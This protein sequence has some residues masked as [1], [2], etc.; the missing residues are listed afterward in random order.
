[1][2]SKACPFVLFILQLNITDA[3]FCKEFG[4]ISHQ[5]HPLRH[6]QR[7]NKTV[8]AFSNE[9]SPELCADFAKL[10]RGLAFNFSPIKRSTDNQF[11]NVSPDEK[12]ASDEFFN[13]EVLECPEFMNFSS[14]VNDTRF[15]YYSLYAR[16]PREWKEA[17]E[18]KNWMKN[19]TDF[20]SSPSER[21]L[22]MS[23][24]NRHVYSAQRKRQLLNG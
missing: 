21:N 1:M 6:C 17:T 16:P 15:D 22:N 8:I 2:I 24:I 3:K 20:S 9:S 19:T 11:R 18:I 7:S 23:S 13:C 12:S 14:V 5:F 10:N 4:K